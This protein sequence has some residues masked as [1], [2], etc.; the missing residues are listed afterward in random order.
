MINVAVEG[1]SDREAAKAIAAYAGHGV[2]QI[3]VAG[4]K[5]KLDTLIPKYNVAAVQHPWVVFRDSDSE[6]PVKLR[7]R[8]TAGLELNANFALRIAH[9]MTEAWL[10]ADRQGF[11]DYFRVSLS[12]IPGDPEVSTNA[13][14][15][16]LTLCA[17]SRSRS[18]RQDVTAAGT[19]RGPLYAVR[20]NEFASEQWNVEA[21]MG[22]SLSLQRAVTRIAQLP[23]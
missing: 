1:A 23:A 22:R 19:A 8:L 2:N 4:G 5:S 20:I 17:G 7:T 15:V 6:C 18:I 12:K 14:Q 3:R 21:A 16:L 10:M 9:S 13:K 11:S